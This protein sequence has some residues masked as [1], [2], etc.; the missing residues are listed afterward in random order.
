EITTRKCRYCATEIPI[1]ATICATCKYHQS[2]WRN[3]LLFLAGLTGF[4]T[5]T[6][7]VLTFSANQMTRLYMM[8]SWRDTLKLFALSN[9]ACE[10]HVL[11]S[12]TGD[13]PVFA[14]FLSVH[15]RGGNHGF[16]LERLVAPNSIELVNVKSDNKPLPKYEQ[17]LANQTGLPTDIIINNT[18]TDAQ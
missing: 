16:P 13:G 10:Q 3:S 14:S 8:L 2:G 15:W 6:A 1:Q 11:L 12:N 4:I 17:V 5:L 7:G 18:S 9:P